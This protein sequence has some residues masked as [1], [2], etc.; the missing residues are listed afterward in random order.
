M[1][2]KTPQK[3]TKEELNQLKDL[4]IKI[5]ELT[6]KFGQVY[7]AKKRLGEQ[8]DSLDK[9]LSKLKKQ[10]IDLASNLTKKYGKGSLN[11]DSGEFIPSK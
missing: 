9:E 10:E 1:A 2:V 6:L 11:I 5:D 7:L 4:Q 3:F 8:E